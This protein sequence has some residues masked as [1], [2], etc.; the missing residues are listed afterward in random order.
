MRRAAG[1]LAASLIVVLGLLLGQDEA[2]ARRE[3]VSATGKVTRVSD[4]DTLWLQLD[5]AGRKR[6]IKLRLEGI[7]APESCQ[8]WGAQARQALSGR[9][10]GRQVRLSLRGRD[11][12]R[13]WLG[14]VSLQGEDVSAWMVREGH[15]WSYRSGRGGGPYA[16]QEAEA[17]A[18]RR[19]LFGA[20]DPMPP[21]V[22]R[23]WHGACP[24][25]RRR[26]A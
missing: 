20:I 16:R 6:P 8:P 12:Y 11:R 21:R 14:N 23:Q 19:G 1:R 10:L 3:P 26:P 24:A 5:G 25:P 22:F 15:A 18:R 13:R 7:D 17:R 4:G 9:L 2:A